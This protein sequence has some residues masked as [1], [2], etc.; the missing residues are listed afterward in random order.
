[1]RNALRRFTAVGAAVAA[2]VALGGAPAGADAETAALA[3]DGFGFTFTEIAGSGGAVF[4]NST[5]TWGDA[6]GTVEWRQ[7]PSN[8]RPGDALTARDLLPDGYGIE[9]RLSTG[10]VASTRGHDSPDSETA[11][12][13]LP[14]G[15]ASTMRARVVRGTFE[16]CSAGYTVSA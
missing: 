11:T 8:G 5:T 4:A 7:D 12:G 1:M 10:R 6:A 13:N 9:G 15:N 16:R 3:A 2:T 14:E